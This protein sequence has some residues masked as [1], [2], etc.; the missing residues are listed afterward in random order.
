MALCLHGDFGRAR[1]SIAAAGGLVYP[2]GFIGVA[3]HDHN[4]S[5]VGLPK[6]MDGARSVGYGFDVS[7]GAWS[8]LRIV[9]FLAFQKSQAGLMRP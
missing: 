7:Y 9:G 5:I 1:A 2:L 8:W 6:C 3:T 4:H